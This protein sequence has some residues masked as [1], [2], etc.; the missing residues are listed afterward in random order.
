MSSPQDNN[1]TTRIVAGES[2]KPKAGRGL[3][4]GIAV[5]LAL[6]IGGG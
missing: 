3:K 1:T 6:L 2:S 4:V 5:G